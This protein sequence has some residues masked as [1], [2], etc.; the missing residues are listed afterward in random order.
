MS[1][2]VKALR[3]GAIMVVRQA[4]GMVLSLG[5]VLLITRLIGPRE[6]GIYAA[7]TGI[8]TFLNNFGTWGTDVYLLRKEQDPTDQDYHQAFTLL[9]CIGMVFGVCLF[10][11]RHQIGLLLRI[12]EAARIEPALGIGLLFSL[13]SIP[14][15]VKLDRDLNFKR[16]AFNELASQVCYFIPA[17]PLALKGQGAWAPVAGWVTQQSMLSFLS[18]ISVPHSF[19]LY[20]NRKLLK[21]MLQYGMSYSSSIWIWQL[22]SLVNPLIVGRFAGPEAVAYVSMSVRITDVLS[23]AKTATWRIALAAL[24]KLNLDRSK[25]RRSITEGMR[26]QAIA[27]GGPLVTFA[28]AAPFFLPRLFGARWTPVLQIFPFVALS[29]LSNAMF[30]LHCSVMY[31]MQKNIKMTLFHATHIVLFAGTAALLVPRYGFIAYG[32]AEIVGLLAY[33][34]I[35]KFTR[36]ALGEPP[37]YRVAVLWYATATAILLVM[38]LGG[39]AQYLGFAF[40]LVPLLFAAERSTLREYL[41]ILFSRATMNEA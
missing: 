8:I 18:Y 35:H 7:S 28:L 30:N 10:C 20:F 23:F 39:N 6:Y 3:G 11:F 36:E 32:W 33:V 4:V 22:R 31:L 2:R 25:L 13:I 29:Y 14:S 37:R 16:V 19:R 26:L 41:R 12:P 9:L 34:V 15:V 40:V 5:G 17:L 38:F 24:G 27:V 1:L 21:Q